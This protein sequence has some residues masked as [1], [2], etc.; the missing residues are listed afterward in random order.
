M[1]SNPL[2]LVIQHDE[3]LPERLSFAEVIACC[4]SRWQLTCALLEEMAKD[5]WSHRFTKGQEVCNE[6][7]RVE[8]FL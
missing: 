1:L 8:K 2:F 6:W 4:G 7:A 5:R 3:H